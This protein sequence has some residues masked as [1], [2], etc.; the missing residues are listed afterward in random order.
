MAELT[1]ESALKKLEKITQMLEGG[2]L[3]LEDSITY[4]EQGIKLSEF[5]AQK[6]KEAQA[7]IT[8]LENK[9]DGEQPV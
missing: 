3:S 1:F 7:K 9:D 2:N 4:Y 5:C 6:L 8:T